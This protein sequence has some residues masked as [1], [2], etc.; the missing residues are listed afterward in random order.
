[1]RIVDVKEHKEFQSKKYI[2][3]K[4]NLKIKEKIMKKKLFI[5][6]LIAI[7]FV[8]LFSF[9]SLNVNAAEKTP[10]EMVSEELENI[11]LP[12]KA[13]ID[14]PV[15][16]ISVYNSTITWE[17]E[18]NQNYITIN[19]GWAKV[20][21]PTDEDKV[22]TLTVTI[23]NSGYADSKEFTITI[24]K[25]TTLTN[26]Y[27][28]TYVLN[29]GTQNA[30]NPAKYKVGTDVALYEPTRG[31]VE[32]LGWYLNENFEGEAL[33][34]LPKGL[35]GDITLYA[36]W[37]PLQI[38]SIKVEQA[39]TK[40][41]YKALEEF[42]PEGLKVVAVY[43]DG[44][45]T[46]ELAL[47]ELE[48]V[49]EENYEGLVL[50][51]RHNQV[52]VKYGEFTTVIEGLTVSKLDYDLEGLFKDQSVVYNGYAQ[53]YQ[54]PNL[55]EGLT[56]VVQGS[57]KDVTATPVALKVLF[58]NNKPEDY[59]DPENI[60]VNLSVT[61]APLTVKVNPTAIN[62]G[63]S[64]PAFSITVEGLLG[65]DK[66]ED[67]GTP[68]YKP[69]VTDTTVSGTYT[70]EVSGLASNNYE[71]SYVAGTLVII[72]G[73][74]EIYVD[75]AQTSV[76]YDGTNKMFE[77]VVK[78]G[79]TVLND[80][81]LNYEHNN[82]TF[83]G[84]IDQGT[85]YVTVSY[86]HEVYGDGTTIVEFKINKAK[87]DVN[88][89][90][91]NDSTVEY[92]G[93]LHGIEIE[94][95]L[96]F[97]VTVEYTEGLTDAGSKVIEA[98][99]TG[100]DN[101]EPITETLKATLTVTPKNLTENMF[102]SIPAQSETGEAVEPAISGKF[103][104]AK[105]ELGTDFTVTYENNIAQGT[106]KAVVTGIGN[107]QGEV[108]LTFEIGESD[109]VKARKA[110]EALE[111]KYTT[112][113]LP[114]E[115][116]TTI[117]SA[118]VQWFS[119]STALGINNANGAITMIQVEEEQVVLVYAL[120]IVNNAA[121]YASFE[122]VVPALEQEQDTFPF[123]NV[124]YNL[125]VEQKN[126]SKTLYSTGIKSGNFGASTED[127]VEAAIINVQKTDGGYYLYV[128]ST[129][130]YIGVVQ[131]GNY[132]NISFDDSASIVW[133][134]NETYNTMT[135]IVGEETYYI[136]TYGTYNTFSVSAISYAATSFTS[137]LQEAKEVTDADKLALDKENLTLPTQ[138]TSNLTLSTSGKNGSVI[139][140]TSSNE[141]VISA[142]GVVTRGSEDVTVKLTA[143][144]TLGEY[145]DTK[146][147]EILVP[148][149]VVV[150]PDQPTQEVN[151]T[152]SFADK[153]QRTEFDTSHQVWVQNGITVTNN[154]A[155]STN[156]VGDYANPARFY[157]SSSLEI[158]VDGTIKQVVFD[159]TGIES[160][161]VTAITDSLGELQFTNVEN[162]IT[163][164]LTNTSD[165]FTIEAL[166][167]QGRAN[168]ITVVYETGS[169]S[170]P[171]QP[172]HEHVLCEECQKC[173]V[174][175]CPDGDVCQGHEPEVPE[176]EHVLCEECQKCTVAD[177]PDGDVCQG[178]EPETPEQSVVTITKTIEEIATTNSWV[179][180]TKYLTFDLNDI[181]NV[182]ATGTTNT[183]KFYDTNGKYTWRI[184][185]SEQATLTFAVKS[186]Y[187]LVSVIL[188][189]SEGSFE[190]KES[191]DSIS[192]TGSSSVI[193][194]T[195]K[196]FITS[197]SVTY[198][199]ISGTVPEQPAHEHI[200]CEE[201]QKCTV[202]DCPDGDV[203][204]GHEPK[205]PEHE[206]VLCEECQKCTVADC[207]DGDVCQGHE[208]ETPE[209]SSVTID[210]SELYS[211]N[212]TLTEVVQNG[213]TLTFSKGSGSTA[214]AYNLTSKEVR[215]Y[216]NNNLTISSS[217]KISS[218]VLEGL[219]YQ[220]GKKLTLEHLVVE[221]G[222]FDQG[223]FTITLDETSNT[224]VIY[225]ANDSTITSGHFKIKTIVV[226]F[227]EN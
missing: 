194:A 69:N 40:L 224:L 93:T 8:C 196:T 173:T 113:E 14:F 60:T 78:D 61:K 163:V 168:S 127:I 222:S 80:I 227:E 1:M 189:Y 94:G 178:H 23:E 21:R 24:L 58:T 48:F 204:Q 103:G 140:W 181:V 200:L 154:K 135:T 166:A 108:E 216:A 86:H 101:Y 137:Y 174:A 2:Q 79:N 100:S 38:E 99:F 170:T 214:P 98:I 148:K 120:V 57:V 112:N 28:I 109:L 83:T 104:D 97:G 9:G 53:T 150:D 126:T 198:K 63:A 182:T 49:L 207:P 193:N 33:E 110:R 195:A 186:G 44:K 29:D 25:G 169:A 147:F 51:G 153:A 56:A 138:T 16:T 116:V 217:N 176:H 85:Y 171:E 27:N 39:P 15:P 17:A 43:N 124:D 36:K 7:F 206:H 54:L 65:E 107:F 4:L 185:S 144:L 75:P 136:G 209:Q 192:L 73:Q 96:P 165:T 188:E 88:S 31:R 82:K 6:S 46:K 129:G 139:T 76:T 125:V 157:K 149:A 67:L 95:K 219:S 143:T 201:C 115:F 177:C 158:K 152:I 225:A 146:E 220:T 123:E 122:F 145:E 118:K 13:I 213:V 130:K 203:C 202:A 91:F 212:T 102:E 84:A 226:N 5:I 42:N 159:C 197:I 77:A 70:V 160:K 68:E 187:E 128:K 32:F 211:A 162:I 210:L 156:N 89:V 114:T 34:A 221:N 12:D 19:N 161:Y 45:T 10:E 105:L 30:N 59:N 72:S 134:Y 52:T 87:F 64:L 223:T 117:N 164:T 133:S 41:S 155:A 141:Q 55:P 18:E 92:D 62:A 50:H 74:Y 190:N 179:A 151:A 142:N 20:T 180:Q 90:E 3:S 37:A 26:E 132:V 175:D 215:L 191:G 199:A 119:T 35:S 11:Y 218:I 121:E 208:P 106:A 22:V 131:S 47:E 111:A 205:V 66:Q 183:G 172:A 184:Y 167:A 71:I 81:T